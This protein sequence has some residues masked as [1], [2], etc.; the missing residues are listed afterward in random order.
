M[1][2]D[3]SPEGTGER[4]RLPLSCSAPLR[5]RAGGDFEESEIDC[6]ERAS[7]GNRAENIGY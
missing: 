2:D 7:I 3:T 1:I 4:S 5:L 6:C